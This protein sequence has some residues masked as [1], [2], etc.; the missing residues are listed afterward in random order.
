MA[1]AMHQVLHVVLT[2]LCGPEHTAIQTKQLGCVS[3]M[4]PCNP[5]ARAFYG[6]QVAIENIHSEMYSLLLD[7]YVKDPQEKHRL[8]HAIDTVPAVKRKA[9]WTIK[10]INR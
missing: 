10:W 2:E 9:D 5:Q 7:S 1:F 6:F 8:F 4:L 3:D